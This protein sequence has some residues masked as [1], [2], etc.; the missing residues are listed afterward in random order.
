VP[1]VVGPTIDHTRHGLDDAHMQVHWGLQPLGQ[2]RIVPDRGWS[3]LG[4]EVRVLLVG[5][6]VGSHDNRGA[7]KPRLD[8]V[9]C[10]AVAPS[11]AEKVLVAA[12]DAH[13]VQVGPNFIDTEPTCLQVR[14]TFVH[15]G[16]QEV[17]G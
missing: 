8:S 6:G 4:E 17:H 14:L 3:G 13:Q 7:R 10:L 16:H 2:L 11:L 5:R 1:E 15:G 12:V 9:S